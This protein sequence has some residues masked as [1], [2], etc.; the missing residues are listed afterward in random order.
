MSGRILFHIEARPQLFLAVYLVRGYHALWSTEEPVTASGANTADGVATGSALGASEEANAVSELLLTL[1]PFLEA[2]LRFREAKDVGSTT[3]GARGTGGAGVSWDWG[4]PTAENS[5]VLLPSAK[6]GSQLLYAVYVHTPEKL[7]EKYHLLLYAGKQ[8]TDGTQR[9]QRD[10]T[11]AV[12]SCWKRA[13][14]LPFYLECIEQHISQVL[15][16]ASQ[17]A[18]AESSE[19]DAAD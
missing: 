10:D 12:Q 18:V 11:D 7:T 3:V 16:D 15:E 13:N 14:L 8:V 17:T 19:S 9:L 2:N 6:P 1:V 4:G 5:P